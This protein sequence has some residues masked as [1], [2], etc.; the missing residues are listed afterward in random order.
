MAEGYILDMALN[1]ER[2]VIGYRYV[3]TGK[4]MDAIRNGADY[5]EA[6]EK[7]IGVYGQYAGAAAYIDP[8]RQ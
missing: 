8:R 6:Y 1:E 3:N 4:M 2:E 7:N 5:R